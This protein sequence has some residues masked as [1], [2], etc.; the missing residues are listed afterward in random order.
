MLQSVLTFFYI[1]ALSCFG[2][3]L[4]A[5]LRMKL[6]QSLMEQDIA[7]FDA[8]KTGE[9]INRYLFFANNFHIVNIFMRR[10]LTQNNIFKV[11]TFIIALITLILC[12]FE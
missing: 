3:R 6:F 8:H 10:Q 1:T 2:E 4:A 9:V 7:F 11:H 12:N 5:R